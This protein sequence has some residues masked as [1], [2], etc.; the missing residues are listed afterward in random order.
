[1]RGIP[2]LGRSA[3][4]Y[5]K[6]LPTVALRPE[7]AAGERQVLGNPN[8]CWASYLVIVGAEA[9]SCTQIRQLSRRGRG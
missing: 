2:G 8:R 3:A 6:A 9:F 1:M 4:V 5:S 7:R